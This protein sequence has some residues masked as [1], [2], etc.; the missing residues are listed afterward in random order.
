MSIGCGS[1]LIFVFLPLD[2]VLEGT[3]TRCSMV[4]ATAG[5][6]V[7]LFGESYETLEYAPGFCRYGAFCQYIKEKVG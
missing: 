3:P 6:E 1:E 7:G 4:R 2:A 5:E